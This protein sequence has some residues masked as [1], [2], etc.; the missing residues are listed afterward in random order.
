MSAKTGRIKAEFK[1][2]I[3]QFL[4]ELIDTFPGIDDFVTLRILV[5]DQVPVEMVIGSFIEDAE[6]LRSKISA[7][8]ETFFTQTNPV[9]EKLGKGE[10]F[11]TIWLSHGMDAANKDVMWRWMEQLLRIVNNYQVNL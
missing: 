2:V 9:F 1:N 5:K 10:T 3:V 11:R 4:D 7:R 6:Y 8:D